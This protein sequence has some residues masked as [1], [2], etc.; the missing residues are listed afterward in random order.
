VLKTTSQPNT[1]LIVCPLER[2]EFNF[3]K[4]VNF[5][6]GSANSPLEICLNYGCNFADDSNPLSEN[7]C[8]CPE[9]LNSYEANVLERQYLYLNKYNP[10]KK[11][12]WEF[13][14]LNKSKFKPEIA[15]KLFTCTLEKFSIYRD[16]LSID[17]FADCIFCKFACEDK[18]NKIIGNADGEYTLKDMME[19]CNCP[20]D[21]TLDFYEE[22]YC[23]YKKQEPAQFSDLEIKFNRKEFQKFVSSDGIYLIKKLNN[24]KIK[25]KL[26]TQERHYFSNYY[27]SL[28]KTQARHSDD[29]FKNIVLKWID[30]KNKRRLHKKYVI[31]LYEF[32]LKARIKGKR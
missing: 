14:A 10:M 2:V 13:V 11:N 5:E 20:S 30:E 23:L 15:T 26:S 22:V 28:M 21:M 31:D 7:F 1:S 29:E 9:G 3:Q 4:S 16:S 32:N 8:K 12:F 18:I 27:L 25:K 24:L 19:T 17:D 6:T